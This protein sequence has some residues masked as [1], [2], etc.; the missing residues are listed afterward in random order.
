MSEHRDW[1]VTVGGRIEN[2][3]DQDSFPGLFEGSL[4]ANRDIHVVALRQPTIPHTTSAVIRISAARKKDAE[5]LA[6][7]LILP[8]YLKVAREIIGEDNFGWV[9]RV[10]AVP[11]PRPSPV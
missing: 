7:D 8:V 2:V 4:R 10:D 9:L 11:S 1:D 6:R 3:T 5:S